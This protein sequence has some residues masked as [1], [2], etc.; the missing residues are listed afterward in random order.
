MTPERNET[1]PEIAPQPQAIMLFAAG[2]GT[3]MG[4][5]TSKLPKPLIPVAGK[6]L[7]DH[8]LE[9][10]RAVQPDR[11]VANL[12][13][14]AEQL[15]DHLT[16]KGV[17]L[18]HEPEILE[19]GGGLKAALPLLGSGPIYTM[20]PDVIWDGPNP[21]PLLRAA[22]RPEKMDGLLMCVPVAQAVGYAG[23]GDFVVDNEGRLRRGPGVIYGGIQILKTEGLDAIQET[24]F[25]LNVL[26]DRML[27]KNRLYCV[28]F[29]GRW[30]DVGHP[31]GLDL[32]EALLAGNDV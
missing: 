22:W 2:F 7:I 24:A 5:L 26:W 31:A 25:S 14:R 32:A 3:R 12:H 30:C 27:A 15:A 20:N 11:I 4:A 16:P 28:T 19:T 6:P 21:L 17:V 29:P 10:T 1:N 23:T 18:S 9:L 13:Y 8:A